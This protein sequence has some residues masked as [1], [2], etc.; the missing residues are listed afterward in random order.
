MR[1]SAASCP[2]SVFDIQG[3]NPEQQRR[4]SQRS[5]PGIAGQFIGRAGQGEDADEGAEC[6]RA[7]SAIQGADTPEE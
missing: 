6:P 2:F 7:Q 5:P 1:P 3:E 4:G